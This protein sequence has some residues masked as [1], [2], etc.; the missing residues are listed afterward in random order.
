MLVIK[1]CCLLL[2]GGLAA[3]HTTL[4]L[5]SDLQ[6]ALMVASLFAV[7]WTRTRP[8]AVLVFGYALFTLAGQATIAKRLDPAFAGDSMLTTVRVVDF[9]RKAGDSIVMD[10]EPVDDS[11]IPR[12]TRVSW[13]EAPVQPVIGDIWQLELRLRQPRGTLNPGVFDYESYLF[14]QKYQASGYVVSGTRNRLVAKGA[15]SRLQTF[16]ANFIAAA[17]AATASES[18]AAVL[19]A[20]GVGARHGITR[21]QWD[22]F[23]A[24][25]TSHL[26]AISGLHVGLAALAAFVVAFAILT[27]VV[28][29]N[30]YVT[31]IAV[32][33]VCAFAYSLVSG[34]GIPARRAILMLSV[35]ALTVWRRRQA[36]PS[37]VVALA[38]IVVFLTDPVA[39][40]RPGF[41]LSFAAV[42]LLLWLAKRK[43]VLRTGWRVVHVTRQLWVMQ[44]FLL[45]GLLPLTALIFQRFAIA[46]T[47][48]NL[49]AVPVFSLVTVPLTLA[50]MVG[51]SFSP[52]VASFLLKLA[53]HSV[54]AIEG[55]IGY[56]VALPFASISLAQIRGGAWAFVWVPLAWVVL[57]RAWPGRQIAL[58]GILAI[59]TWKPAAPAEGCFDAWI[60]D[61]GQGLAVAVQTRT[62][63][64]LYDTGMAWRGGGSAADQVVLPF[65][66]SRRIDRLD[67]LVISHADLDHSGGVSR[68]LGE[69]TVGDLLT[70]ETLGLSRERP[71]ISGQGWIY[72]NVRFEV[73]YPT[74]SSTGSDTRDGNASS[75]VLRVSAGS[76]SLLLTGDIEA[77]SERELVQSRA[78]FAADIALVPHHG[79][80]TSSTVP[81]VDSVYPDFA[82]VSAGYANRWGFPKKGVVERWEAMGAEVLNT[83]TS[84]ALYFRVCSDDGVVR[85][86]AERDQRRRFWHAQ[87]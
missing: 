81:F 50:G 19:A 13:F 26:M 21:E 48:V 30:G 80:L 58:L 76:Y 31:A 24:S 12:R 79:S 14:R 82:V 42:V 70:G 36:R 1:T 60:L 20:I 28:H 44:V 39:T 85:M 72:D 16:Q 46:A 49:V 77:S 41:H 67:R 63:V 51:N 37:A 6:I 55:L 61:V 5:V 22:R 57:P 4:P 75:C 56:V 3:Q 27:P 71:C 34:F 15:R 11:R 86:R 17:D 47:P 40:M 7:Y 38:G 2:L 53:A 54:D 74:R 73:L 45:F 10:I 59:A 84:G 68:I 62:S 32:G 69:L 78:S 43:D 18:A 33:A 25:G 83:A 66:R 64:L 23:A 29:T 87:T 9:P 65:F 52:S 35:V 8:I